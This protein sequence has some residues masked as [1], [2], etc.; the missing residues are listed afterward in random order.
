MTHLMISK[1]LFLATT[2]F[3]YDPL[4]WMISLGYAAETVCLQPIANDRMM[5][6]I[7]GI[8]VSRATKGAHPC[9]TDMIA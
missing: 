3:Y 7:L 2:L 1:S 5:K 6:R 4:K 8:L 9:I